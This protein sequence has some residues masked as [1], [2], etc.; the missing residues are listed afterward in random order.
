MKCNQV[1]NNL[2]NQL[3]LSSELINMLICGLKKKNIEWSSFIMLQMIFFSTVYLKRLSE[4]KSI[5]ACGCLFFLC[6]RVL[7]ITYTVKLHF[8]MSLY[9]LRQFY[10]RDP[11]K[12]R[13]LHVMFIFYSYLFCLLCNAILVFFFTWYYEYCSESNAFCL[14]YYIYYIVPLHQIWMLV[15]WQ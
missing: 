6:W 11:Y 1:V 4:M 3:P 14:L 13:H 5:C 12:Y 7:S 15:V 2:N 8:E 9:F 10:S